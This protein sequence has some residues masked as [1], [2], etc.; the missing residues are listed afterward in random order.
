M[1]P[2]TCEY[3]PGSAVNGT[4]ARKVAEVARLL[5]ISDRTIYVW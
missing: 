1:A 2:L 5:G 3:S 4:S